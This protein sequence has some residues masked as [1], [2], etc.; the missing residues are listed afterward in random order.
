[1][2]NT[3][4]R[5]RGGRAQSAIFS[6]VETNI[7]HTYGKDLVKS[8]NAPFKQQVA[9]YQ[10]LNPHIKELLFYFHNTSKKAASPDLLRTL[11]LF[12][13]YAKTK[14]QSE[15]LAE[16]VKNLKLPLLAPQEDDILH[17][18]MDPYTPTNTQRNNEL[19]EYIYSVV[20][21]NSAE[22]SL[23]RGSGWNNFKQ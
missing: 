17:S 15:I 8:G 13:V 10:Q 19:I 1:M 18:Y 20:N 6:T 2:I 4:K 12:R 7:P 21:Y 5:K 16:I 11:E 9:V 23:Y 22:E 3:R 14:P